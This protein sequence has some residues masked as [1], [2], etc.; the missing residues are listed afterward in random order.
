MEPFKTRNIGRWLL[1]FLLL[2]P[3]YSFSSYSDSDEKPHRAIMGVSMGAFGA[4][5]FGLRHPEKFQVIGALG[6]P[7]EMKGLITFI[8]R[9]MSNY[10]QWHS[11]Y[12]N[13]K[14][15]FNMIHDMNI[16][17]G[18]LL[19]EGPDP[20]F[21]E[22]GGY[23][24]CR[25]GC[26]G[27]HKLVSATF[28]GWNL[29]TILAID[30]NDNGKFDK[31]EPL[32]HHMFEPFLN[33]NSS[34]WH[35]EGESFEDVGLD[36]IPGTGDHGEDNGRWDYDPDIDT[37]LAHDPYALLKDLPDND[38]AQLHFY[39]DAGRQDEFGFDEQNDHFTKLLFSRDASFQYLTFDEFAQPPF[40]GDHAYF[41]YVGD[42]VGFPNPFILKRRLTNAVSFISSK[43]QG[44]K[45]G[46]SIWDWVYPSSLEMVSVESRALG[47][48]ASY[49]IYLPGGYTWEKNRT[50]PVI[51]FLA[52]YGE[53]VGK[54]VN[55]LTKAL[56][57][58]MVYAGML[59]K[60]ILVFLDGHSESN[61]Q[62]RKSNFY[63]NQIHP[64]G[65]HWEDFL[66]ELVDDID[67]NY[68]TQKAR[69]WY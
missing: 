54:M 32:V 30:T 24:P 20:L 27:R 51:Y 33:T 35:E 13:L 50:Y 62:G 17:F 21:P 65:E 7:V 23:A 26:S 43:L 45:Y 38:L 41:R 68:R 49:G 19:Y 63:V 3:L 6:G 48:K 57:D 69:R 46:S 40:V 61:I 31:G 39:L 53:R 60:T 9:T 18:N 1:F 12:F 52:G 28:K 58:F 36:G 5:H 56:I 66:L 4:L 22:A 59:K 67:N 15:L 37:L 64:E 14:D 2:I 34:G 25:Y 11:R 42:H 16:S 47:R 10:T 55:G 8:S 29:P 44:G